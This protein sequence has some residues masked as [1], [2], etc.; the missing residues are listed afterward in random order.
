MRFD[1]FWLCS[2][3][4]RH[5]PH[6]VPHLVV[7]K[8]LESTFPSVTAFQDVLP[9]ANYGSKGFKWY[10][11][12]EITGTW[13]ILAMKNHSLASQT[14]IIYW[15][16]MIQAFD[17]DKKGVGSRKMSSFEAQRLS[18]TVCFLSV[19]DRVVVGLPKKHAHRRLQQW[20]SNLLTPKSRLQK[21]GVE[22]SQIQCHTA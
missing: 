13:L 10:R 22:D 4:I 3:F 14:W 7:Q 21:K 20:D 2:F 9:A 18:K 17:S 15:C 12:W 8:H 1:A 11:I 5:L 16:Q 19:Q 6:M